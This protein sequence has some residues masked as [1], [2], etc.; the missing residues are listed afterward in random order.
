MGLIAA[1]FIIVLYNI[2]MNLS[3]KIKKTRVSGMALTQLSTRSVRTNKGICLPSLCNPNCIKK[4]QET[5]I[6]EKIAPPHP[7]YNRSLLE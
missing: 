1:L 3:K 4:N 7:L 2:D 5:R 6:R